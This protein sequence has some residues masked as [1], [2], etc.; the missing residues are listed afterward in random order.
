MAPPNA[1]TVCRVAIVMQRDTRQVINTFH[2]EKLAGWSLSD[3]V[4]LAAA[5]HTWWSTYYKPMTTAMYGLVQIQCRVYNPVAPL[6]YDLNISPTEVGTRPGQAEAGNVTLSMSERTG[7]AGRK[8]R[9]RM[10]LAGVS[11]TDT[12]TNDFVASTLVTL[13]ANALANL[14]TGGLPAGNILTIFHRGTNTTTDVIA[15]VIENIIDS[16]RRR[17][18]GRGR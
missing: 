14:I 2:V 12:N 4:A 16:Q 5:V 10:Y 17:L 15:Y 8:Y 9:G 11:E 18:P 1:P 6:A 3:L 7:L 13:A